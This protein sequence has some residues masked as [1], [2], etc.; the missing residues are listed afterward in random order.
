MSRYDKIKNLPIYKKAALIFQL[1]D[2]L[3]A[4]LPNDHL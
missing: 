1:V 2:S 3:M 4:S